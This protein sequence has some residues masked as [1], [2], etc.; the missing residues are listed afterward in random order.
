MKRTIKRSQCF[1]FVIYV[2]SDVNDIAIKPSTQFIVGSGL[3][4]DLTMNWIIVQEN[5]ELIHEIEH[6]G[7][8]ETDP[9]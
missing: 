6:T 1:F 2:L 9:R 3:F 5:R 8:I 7:Q 4:G